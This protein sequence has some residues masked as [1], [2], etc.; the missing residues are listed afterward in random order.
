MEPKETVQGLEEAAVRRKTLVVGHLP[1]RSGI[2][3]I[4]DFFKNVGR[5]V[6]VR[7]PLSYNGKH[8]GW[9]FVEFASANEADK[10]LEEKH[11]EYFEH[12]KI[13]LKKVVDTYTTKYCIEHK[14][15]YYKNDDYL[16]LQESEAKVEDGVVL[17]AN[18]SPQTTKISDIIDFFRSKVVSVRL[19]VN[20]EGEHVGYCFVEFASAEEANKALE[21][22]NR[23]YLHDHEIF[24]MRGFY[25]TPTSSV[26]T[27]RNKTLYVDSLSSQTEISDIIDF[28]KDVGEVVHVRSFVKG[29]SEDERL[30]FCVVEFASSNQAEMAL[31]KKNG[32]SLHGCKIFLKAVK[33][34]PNRRSHPN[35]CKDHK[36]WYEDYL[37]Q[38]SLLSDVEELDEETPE[39]I[40][41]RDKTVFV[42]NITLDI[43]KSQ[44][45]N[46]FKD[47]GEVVSVRLI[48]DQKGKRVGCGFIEFASAEEATKAVEEKNGARFFVSVA[49]KGRQYPFRPNYNLQDKLWYEYNLLRESL[50]SR[51]DL[52]RM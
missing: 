2:S 47:V 52:T 41:V 48:V 44:I 45:I 30:R 32:E 42:A 23:R 8:V 11:G 50:D 51:S 12:R 3:D 5:V 43:R 29:K 21:K 4:I 34:G 40:A 46:F 13:F 24:L 16:V 31:E 39:E 7:I 25:E 22:K 19:I 9:A 49:K 37:R 15:W 33:T 14:V 6:R 27:V 28:F 35:H 26:E 17:V 10:A 18:L 38:E 1:R 36:L 20:C